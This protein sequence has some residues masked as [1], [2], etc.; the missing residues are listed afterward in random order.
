MMVDLSTSGQT[1]NKMYFLIKVTL[2]KAKLQRQQPSNYIMLGMIE[3]RK[4]DHNIANVTSKACTEKKPPEKR[5]GYGS[6]LGLGF[7]LQKG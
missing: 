7:F 1:H 5:S 2:L 6:W 4:A 3:E